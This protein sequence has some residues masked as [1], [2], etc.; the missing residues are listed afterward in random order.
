V[1]D[2]SFLKDLLFLKELFFKN[3][4]WKLFSLAAAVLLWIAV[5][6]EPELSTFISVPVE[7]KNL[8]ADLDISSDIVESVILEVRGPSGELR[9]LPQSRRRY[10]VVLDITDIAPGRHTFTIDDSDVRLPRGVRLVRTI[11]AQIRLSVEQTAVRTVPV[12]VRF[13]GHLPPDLEAQAILQPP[14]LPIAGP[15]SR[16]ARVTSI[17]T[18]PLVLKPEP[19]TQE[20]HVAAY[21]NDPRVRLAQSSQVTVKVTISRKSL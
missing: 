12:E 20:F 8:S 19:G 18:D 2:L 5:A 15:A 1:K 14:A 21:V 13:A 16:V 9:D 4:G 7:Y 10:A 6:S 11:P 3:A 17:A